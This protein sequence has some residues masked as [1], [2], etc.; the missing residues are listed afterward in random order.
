M[1]FGSYAGFHCICSIK[2]RDDNCA[3]KQ[4]DFY[5]TVAIHNTDADFPKSQL[6]YDTFAGVAA[7]NAV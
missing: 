2:C 4:N 1:P 3:V 7:E 6:V 5:T